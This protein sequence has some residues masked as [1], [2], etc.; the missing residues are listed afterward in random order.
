MTGTRC[1]L[2]EYEVS[3][4]CPV[5]PIDLRLPCVGRVGPLGANGSGPVWLEPGS[6]R[7]PSLATHMA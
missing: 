6:A 2:E 3:L 7:E 1:H 5:I 4:K